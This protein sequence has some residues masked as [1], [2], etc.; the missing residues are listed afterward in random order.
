MH[1]EY[2]TE[3]EQYLSPLVP[4]TPSSNYWY[5]RILGTASE[6]TP[7]DVQ[8][9]AEFMRITPGVFGA[10][11]PNDHEET[12]IVVKGELD[13]EDETGQRATLHEGETFF[14]KKG[15]IIKYSVKRFALV[16]KA[17]AYPADPPKPTTQ[18]GDK[19]RR[20]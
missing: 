14:I 17:S 9:Y 1:F 3:G 13:L 10:G 6:D 4:G 18:E 11:P 19:F 7:K 2:R 5:G 12:G 16:F 8:L 15:A 20:F